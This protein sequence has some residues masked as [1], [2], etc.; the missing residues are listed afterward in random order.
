MDRYNVAEALVYHTLAR[1]SDP[2]MGNA[3]LGKEITNRRLHRIWA[4]DAAYVIERTPAEFLDSALQNNVKAIMFN[5]QMRDVQID[6]SLR[7]AELAAMLQKRRIPLIAAYR[8]FNYGSDMINW[9]QLT[10]FCNAFPELPVIS[11]EWR[12]L[13]NRPM[14]DALALTK[15]LRICI[16]SIWQAQMVNQICDSFGSRRLIFSLGLP[17]LDPASFVPVITYAGLDTA[18]MN[19]L[20]SENIQQ[21]L[22]EADYE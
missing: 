14:F 10:D 18:A 8:R 20:A 4:F 15:N 9:Y 6:R 21:I 22:Q 3:A 19:A 1:D 12:T 5:P 11:W 17:H 13:A 7:L 2:D 16:T